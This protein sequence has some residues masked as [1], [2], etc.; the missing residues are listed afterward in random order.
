MK[1]YA[2]LSIDE[3][4]KKTG[5][6]EIVSKFP[7]NNRDE[8][9]IAYT[10][11]VAA[12]CL[13]IAKDAREAYNLTSMKNTVA[14]ITDGSSVLGL[15]NIGPIAALP[16]MEGK[17]ALF[18]RFANLD[19]IPIVLGTQNTEE[20]I[21]AIRAIAPTFGGI[22]LEDI[23]APRCFEIE[24]RL[25]K[26]LQIPIM[27]DDQHGTAIVV[28]AGLINALKVTTKKKEGVK[29]VINGAGAAGIAITKLIYL[30]GFKNII[31]CDSKGM[32]YKDRN[33]LN[34][35]KIEISK[36]TNSENRKGNLSEAVVGADIFIGVS[37]GS[38]LNT[39]DVKRMNEGSVIFALANPTPEITPEEAQSGGTLIYASGRSDLPNQVNNS[40]VFPGIF[41]GAIDTRVSEI[42]DK[43]KLAAAEAL[44]NLVENPKPE[45]I[46]PGAFDE[47]VMQAVA[48]AVV[49]AAEK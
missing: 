32:I 2:K 38:V 49:D 26:E 13:L 44:A 6:L 39:D 17:C 21:A 14:V 30:Y 9:S 37:K 19:A 41:R 20:I 8:L 23:S 5:K 1:D 42:T 35:E 43:M 36:I 4:R 46:I 40:L 18:K 27:H 48:K 7:I 12:P 45:K 10:P 11:G 22:N 25:K 16:V 29:V 47:G 34:K 15:G 28:L 31:M 33:D 24:E 3:H